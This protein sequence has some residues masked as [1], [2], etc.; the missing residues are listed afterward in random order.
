MKSL[1]LTILLLLG[2][3]YS[4]NAQQ[5]ETFEFDR[6]IIY[7]LTYQTDSTDL[8]SRGQLD[9]ELLL[10]DSLSLFESLRKWRDD[11]TYYASKE[12]KSV[13]IGLWPVNPFNYQIIKTGG[14]IKTYDSPFGIN[15][16]GKDVI[17]YYE[18]PL[19]DLNWNITTDTMTIANML[20]QRA[21]LH[22]GNRHW[23]AWFTVE[24][25]IQDG[26]YKFGGLPGLVVSVSDANDFWRFEMT[27]IR[28]VTK[29]VVINFQNWYEFVPA[30]KEQL[31]K[32]R[33]QYQDNMFDIYETAGALHSD[34]AVDQKAA[35]EKTKKQIDDRVSKDNNWIELYP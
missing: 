21:D 17:Y 7:Q 35:L 23:T 31:Y 6:Q 25:P 9:F 12:T 24:I 5:A 10:N 27:N 32:E 34:E 11:S 28:N 1:R 22:F 30:T 14:T 4:A 26:P 3:I 16:N 18:E 29:T 20:C 8:E 19:Q 13:T 2:L 33:R 15:L